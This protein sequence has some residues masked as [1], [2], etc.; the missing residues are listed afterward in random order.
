M[1]F[2]GDE[3]TG[4]SKL[5]AL[6]VTRGPTVSSELNVSLGRSLRD[7]VIFQLWP[8]VFACLR[9]QHSASIVCDPDLIRSV[10][11]NP[12]F[13]GLLIFNHILFNGL[14][15]PL[16]VGVVSNLNFRY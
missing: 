7:P 12:L 8:S 3:N 5:H 4:I 16:L 2:L 15:V 9:H 14:I 11:F 1:P 13:E 6:E 10:G